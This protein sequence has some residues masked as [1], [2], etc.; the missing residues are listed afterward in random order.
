MLPPLCP[1]SVSPID[2][3]R[4]AELIERGHRATRAWLAD[5]GDRLPDPERFLALH[6]HTSDR[7]GHARRV[8]E[9]APTNSNG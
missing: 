4:S 5:G 6:H 1:V 3:S 9:R 7:D 8:P 2:F